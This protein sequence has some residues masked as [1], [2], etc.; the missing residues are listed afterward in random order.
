MMA[1]LAA[2]TLGIPRW[3]LA[4]LAIALVVLAIILLERADDKSNQEIGATVEREAQTRE[5]LERTETGNAVREEAERQIGSG[6]GTIVYDQCMRYD[7]NAPASCER[8]L[9][10]RP[11]DQS[12]R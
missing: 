8:F 9:P 11:S 3:V 2:K 12:G 1:F 6:T 7:R 5:V 10:E 4:A